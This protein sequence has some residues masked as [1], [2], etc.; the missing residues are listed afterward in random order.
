MAALDWHGACSMVNPESEGSN[1]KR[2]IIV[3]GL[4]TVGMSL[5]TVADAKGKKPV[6]CESWAQYVPADKGSSGSIVICA[7]NADHPFI[8]VDVRIVEAKDRDGKPAKFAIGYR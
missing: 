6:V 8:M 7:D 2:F 4:V 3:A 1:M 5:A